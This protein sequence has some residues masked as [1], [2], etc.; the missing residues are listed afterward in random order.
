M[1]AYSLLS[2]INKIGISLIVFLTSASSLKAQET[3][4]A[5]QS[6]ENLVKCAIEQSFENQISEQK[7]NATRNLEGIAKQLLNP[8]LQ[9]ENLQ[10]G[11]E[12]S[13]TS[14]TL[15]FDVRLGGK[16]SAALNEAQAE[17]QKASAEADLARAQ[18]KLDLTLKLYRLAQLNHESKLEEETVST[19]TK[20]IKQY[21][22]KAALTPEQEV[23]L[24]IFKISTSEH[25][26]NLVKLKNE[27][28]KL[29]QEILSSTR[30]TEDLII[31]NLPS[32]K[33]NWPEISEKA[34]IDSSPNVRFASSELF[35]AKAL[36][37]KA[38][39]EA[40]P[41]LKIGPSVKLQKDNSGSE[42][43]VGLSL[44]MPLP[45][46]NQNNAGRA[47]SQQKVIEAQLNHTLVSRK[48]SGLRDQLVGKYRTTVTS[49]KSLISD[50]SAEEKH[51]QIERHFFKGMI[52][53]SLVI[54]AH[55]QLIEFEQKRNESEREAIEALGS[56]LIID[57]QFTE[58]IL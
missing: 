51:K 32:H 53:S 15:L 6:Y 2:K 49:L 17:I 54:E 20:I 48:V 18:F 3:T 33:S 50:G 25:Q 27:S 36:K 42:N 52:S 55:R 47:Y 41:D 38:D 26:V 28:Q 30:L 9:I 21:Q 8:E 44:S 5:P 10:K 34:Q 57:N 4:C 56:I 58:V 40:W 16:K 31:K 37:E 46:L 13:E 22:N 7:V 29:F 39:A 24:S 19:F 14:A 1:D 23:S 45:F 12:K 43:F 35:V 11:S